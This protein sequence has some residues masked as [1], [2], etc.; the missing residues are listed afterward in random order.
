MIKTTIKQA[1][2]S[3]RNY[4]ISERHLS[5]NTV[6]S[7]EEIMNGFLNYLD[8]NF[9][10]R[11]VDEVTS[12]HIIN[13]TSYKLK[14]NNGYKLHTLA[15]KRSIIRAF[16]K[17]CVFDCLITEEQNPAQKVENYKTQYNQLPKIISEQQ[18]FTIID[19]ATDQ[20]A[21]CMFELFYATG[22]RVSEL[23]NISKDD[24]YLQQEYIVIRN[25]KGGR[26]RMVPIH[27]LCIDKLKNYLETIRCNIVP[28]NQKRHNSLLFLQPNGK[29]YTRSKVLQMVV[30]AAKKAGIEQKVT[31]H[32]FRHSFATHLYQRGVELHLIQEMLGHVSVT[33]TE[34][35]IHVSV[36]YLRQM[37]E[38]YHPRF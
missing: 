14:I 30:S 6:N 35:Y 31:P 18:A 2:S 1:I 32:T 23:I 26:E 33:T 20:T 7:Y 4:L 38:M 12:Q 34:I 5:Q 9:N 28:S 3:Y 27:Q 16:F 37:M 13:Y 24:V 22:I 29:H 8:N 36:Q 21:S 10:I 11:F 15:R 19:K 25:G 17:Y